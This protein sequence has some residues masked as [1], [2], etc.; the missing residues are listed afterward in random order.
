MQFARILS[1]GEIAM[2]LIGLVGTKPAEGQQIESS[3]S[4]EVASVKRGDP[5]ATRISVGIAPGGRLTATNATVKMLIRQA[6]DLRDNQ[7]SGGPSWLDSEHY[8]VEAKVGD[9]VTIPAGPAGGALLRNMLRSLLIERFGLA[10]HRESKEE[11]VYELV[12]AKGGRS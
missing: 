5:N 7:I 1:L 10:F 11:T 2:A 6:F 3:S 12:V 4:F 9:G 8:D